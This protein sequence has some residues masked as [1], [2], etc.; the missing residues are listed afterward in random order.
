MQIWIWLSL[1]LIRDHCQICSEC[2]ALV[3]QTRLNSPYT[4]DSQHTDYIAAEFSEIVSYCGLDN[5]TYSL[6][7]SATYASYLAV[8]YTSTSAASSETAGVTSCAGQTIPTTAL[9]DATGSRHRRQLLDDLTANSNVSAIC[10]SLAVEHQVTTGDLVVASGNNKCN[11]T[12]NL[13]L[14]QTCELLEVSEGE[15]W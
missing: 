6:S 14:P 9:N 15:T 7:P 3:L 10:E 2:F 8:N 12:S 1:L 5:N 13:C 4:P 11:F